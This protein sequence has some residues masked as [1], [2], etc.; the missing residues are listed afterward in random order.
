VPAYEYFLKYHLGN[1]RVSFKAITEMTEFKASFENGTSQYENNTF[2]NYP[3]GGN[4][5]PM[6]AFDH[7][8]SGTTYNY[9]NLL[10]GAA[11]SQ[12]GLAKS[13]E[14]MAGDVF[15]LEVFGKYETTTSSGT[16]LN[17]LFSALTSAFNLPVS[18]GSG[19]ESFQAR[20][21]FNGIYGSANF[22]GDEVP[23]EDGAAPK[24]F[25]NYILFDENF[26]FQD[27]GFDQIDSEAGGLAAPHDQ[28]SLHVSESGASVRQAR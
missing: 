22:I 13:F 8:D 12:I 5:S 20:Q 4:L 23:Y 28:M 15:D 19:L 25:L 21:A 27:F 14:V 26:V 11:N 9:S 3:T 6:P 10:N 7:T 18:G 24:A 1:V 17:N 16:N 2:K